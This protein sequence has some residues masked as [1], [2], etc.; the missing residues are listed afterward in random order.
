[1]SK[2]WRVVFL[3]TPQFA[4]ICLQQILKN[5][6]LDVVGVVTQPDRPAGRKLELTPSPVKLL[7]V[8]K[9]LK[10]LTP[11][12][13]NRDPGV[14]DE[15]LSWKADIAVVVA[16]G[17]ILSQRFLDGFPFGAVNVHASLLPRWRG[18][19]PIQRSIEAGDTIT[20]VALQKMV[21]ELDAGDVIGERSVAIDLQIN[22]LQLHDL[23]AAESCHLLDQDLLKYLQG[24]VKPW[25]QDSSQ[26]TYA[27]K[28]DKAESLL[29]W[30]QPALKLHNKVR[31]F[32]WG[33][34]AYTVYQGK[35]IKIHQTR[36]RFDGPSL[37]VSQ[38]Q[39]QGSELFVG[40]SEGVLEILE[41]QPESKKRMKTQEF[42]TGNTL[43][44]GDFFETPENRT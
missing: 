5:P 11:Q 24:E 3:G 6:S 1:M 27:S 26:V 28:I 20:G 37:Q 9:G 41:L 2:K 34:G 10:V 32:T 8:S 7:A 25:A 22:S 36:C 29:D 18:A 4:E 21:K 38:V 17:Q 13:V 15:I 40:T 35:K 33:P 30:K 44:S 31:A 16:F 43:R 39:V 19:A 42:L 23:L 14:L 12:S